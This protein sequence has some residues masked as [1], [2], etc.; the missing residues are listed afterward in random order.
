MIYDE[1]TIDFIIE[2]VQHMLDNTSDYSHYGM[3]DIN[4]MDSSAKIETYKNIL[5][6]LQNMKKI[7]AIN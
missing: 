4:A 1:A 3:Y 6:M 7:K 2:K 5:E